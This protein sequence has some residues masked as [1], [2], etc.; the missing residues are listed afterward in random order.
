MLA[1]L[2]AKGTG[3]S[4]HAYAREAL[5]EPLGV[6]PTQW[7]TDDEG[8][9]FAASGARMTTR[10]LARIGLM[11]L[12]RGKVN[13]RVVVPA[14]WL[15]R[16]VTPSV[17]ADEVRR[18]GYQCLCAMWDLASRRGGLPDAWSGCGWLRARAVSACSCFPRCNW[19]SR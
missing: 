3:Q 7:V 18:Y 1:C 5:F 2:I 9:P 17:S 10:D 6:G 11:M 13:G 12:D 15:D 19:P 4:L 8:E 16:C 14:A